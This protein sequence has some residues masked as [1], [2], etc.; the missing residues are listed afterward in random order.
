MEELLNKLI[1]KGFR[2]FS[3]PWITAI[4]YYETKKILWITS[5]QNDIEYH[6]DFSLRDIV[7]VS[8]WIWQFCEE[9]GMVKSIW[10]EIEITNLNEWYWVIRDTDYQYRVIVSSLKNEEELEEFLLSNIQIWDI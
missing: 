6:D 7:S 1:E 5:F 4:K 8:S 3:I 10:S 2:P 9:S